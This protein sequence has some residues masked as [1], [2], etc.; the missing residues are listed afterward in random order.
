MNKEQAEELLEKLKLGEISEFTV[1]KEDFLT[2]REQ[3]VKR[4][5]FKHFRGN[6]KHGGVTTYTYLEE[7][8]S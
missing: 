4:S 6:A 1:S 2:F 5:D 3:L 8:R 7:A